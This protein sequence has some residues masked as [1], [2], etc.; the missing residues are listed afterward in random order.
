MASNHGCQ[1]PPD[2]SSPAQSTRSAKEYDLLCDVVRAHRGTV[3]LA[4][5]NGGS[6]ILVVTLPRGEGRQDAAA[7]F[8]LLEQSELEPVA[9]LLLTWLDGVYFA[10]GDEVGRHA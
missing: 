2:V 10:R 1:Q 6:W 5:E 7:G 8:V 3:R 4:R 9:A